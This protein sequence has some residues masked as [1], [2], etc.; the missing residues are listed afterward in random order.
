MHCWDSFAEIK[1]KKITFHTLPK[2]LEFTP[3]EEKYH[4][5]N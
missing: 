1:D 5:E 4:I 3:K 2:E